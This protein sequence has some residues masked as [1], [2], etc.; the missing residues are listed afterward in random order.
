MGVK[1]ISQY[2][3][4]GQYD[5][6]NILEAP[7]VETVAR[8]A[9]VLNARGTLKTTTLPALSVDEFIQTLKDADL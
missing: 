3:L 9:T 5:F 6:L 4:L 2:A 7:D 1:V 8:M